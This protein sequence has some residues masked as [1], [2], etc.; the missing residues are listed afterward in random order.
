MEGQG[1]TRAVAPTGG[2]GGSRVQLYAVKMIYPEMHSNLQ[3]T[4]ME[5]SAVITMSHKLP[6][7]KITS[8][9]VC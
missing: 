4:T 9:T 1:H 2:T 5:G 3:Y 8:S 6:T 7:I